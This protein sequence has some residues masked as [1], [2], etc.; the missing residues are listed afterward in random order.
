MLLSASGEMRPLAQALRHGDRRLRFAAV[1]S[2]L[3]FKPKTAFPGASYV[4]ETLGFFAGAVGRRRV[5]IANPRLEEARKLGGLFAQLGYEADIAATGNEM[6]QLALRRPEY[7]IVLLSDGLDKIESFHTWKQLR[8]DPRTARLLVALLGREEN[9]TSLQLRAQGDKLARAMPYIHDSETLTFQLRML[10]TKA[11]IEFVPHE[12]RQRQAIASIG[13]LSALA[14]D[15]VLGKHYDLLRQ[16]APLLRALFGEGLIE[17]AAPA[18]GGLGTPEAQR[19]LV[20]FASDPNI[21]LADREIAAKAFAAAV[22][23]RGVLLTSL[24]IQQAYDRYNA[25]AQ[26]DA[27]T[28]RVLGA[29]LDT[30]ERK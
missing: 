20:E 6:M 9:L 12:E 3:K 5:L 14:N 30:I 7:E 1:Q 29:L 21:D 24:E 26:L 15:P 27:D 10:F 4:P 28:Q 2:I 16:E 13:H 18:L 17:Y 8:K 19:A 23:R 25:S 22:A 11:S